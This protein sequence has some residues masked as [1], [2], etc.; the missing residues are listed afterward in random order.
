MTVQLMLLGLM[1][2]GFAIFM[3]GLLGVSIYVAT[4][5]RRQE[6]APARSVTPA[7]RAE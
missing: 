4:G 7:R 6:T 1:L 2:S 5:E 3:I